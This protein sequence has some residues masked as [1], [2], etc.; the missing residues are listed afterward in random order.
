MG[1]HLLTSRPLLVQLTQTRK[2]DVLVPDLDRARGIFGP[3]DPSQ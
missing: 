2:G 3:Q 1:N